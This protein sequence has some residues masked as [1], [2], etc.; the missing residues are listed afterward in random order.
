MCPYC[1][2][3]KSSLNIWKQ[4]IDR[5]HPGHDEKKFVCEKCSMGFIFEASLNAHICEK[6]KCQKCDFSTLHESYMRFHVKKEHENGICKKCQKPLHSGTCHGD[7]KLT[8]KQCNRIF[9]TY[10]SVKDHVLSVHEK[11]KDFTC[12]FCG[13]HFA[14]Q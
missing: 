2:K 13:K 1:N 14:T 4:H 10:V 8:C 9:K 5:K 12:E 7:E 6:I 3:T 11:R